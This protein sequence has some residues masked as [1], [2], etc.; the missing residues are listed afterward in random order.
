M[1]LS[2][3]HEYSSP[4]VI[5]LEGVHLLASVE[6]YKP[7]RNRKKWQEELARNR[8]KEREEE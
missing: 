8:K 2:G 1:N 4:I 3:R 6:K 5:A 7:S